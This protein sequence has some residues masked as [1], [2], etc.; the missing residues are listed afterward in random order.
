MRVINEMG[1]HPSEQPVVSHSYEDDVTLAVVRAISV[2]TDTPPT[3]IGP[4]G[5]VI[6][7]D[8][9]N[10]LFAPT[11]LNQAREGRGSGIR[12]RFEGFLVVID[13]GRRDISLYE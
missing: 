4:L 6:D 2:A 1:L 8:A 11:L 12:F 9:L 7:A 5:E 10:E 13:A 3:E